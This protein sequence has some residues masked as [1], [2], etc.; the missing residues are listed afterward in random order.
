[1]ETRSG[2]N[3]ATERQGGTAPK[4]RRGRPGGRGGMAP[5]LFVLPF[6]L[7]YA[8]FLIYPVLAAFRLSFY[9]S[10]GFG[11]DTF[12][13]LANYTRLLRDPRYLE[14]LR[15]TTLYALASVFILS[16][17]ALLVAISIRSFVVPTA[18]FK[19]FYR[20]VFFLPFITSF[21]VIALMFNL[22]FNNEFGL[23]NNALSSLGLPTLDWLRN[24]RVALPA[25]ILVGIWTYLGINAL[26]FLAGLQN[27]P[28]EVIEAAAVDGA[29]RL[30]TFWRVTLPLL[31]PVILFVVVQ[32]TIF[33]YQIFEIPFLLTGGGP[34]DSTLTLAIY[35][36]EVG[37]RQFDRG[38]AAA[39]GYSM[40]IIA[41]VLA[42]V[43]LLAARRFDR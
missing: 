43:Q 28:V 1:M 32:A 33:S 35:L 25:I 4:P 17:L 20:V 7:I 22:V 39:I 6:F 41:I 16:P 37:F 29:G 10:S 11:G 31:R 42:A 23:L 3:L 12:A 21:V 38:Y 14:A 19:S 15:N 26:Y 18:T 9:E 27:V 36:Y 24:E 8:V 34:S 5:Y 2:E 40:A 30:Q 13:G